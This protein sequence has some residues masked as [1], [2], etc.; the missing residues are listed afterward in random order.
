MRRLFSHTGRKRTARR[1]KPRLAF[2]PRRH[3]LTDLEW[4]VIFVATTEWIVDLRDNVELPCNLVNCAFSSNQ[5]GVPGFLSA[6]IRMDSDA[7]ACH[8]G[9]VTES[10]RFRQIDERQVPEIGRAHV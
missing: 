4:R 5:K 8:A 3:V 6:Q 7:T 1:T 10:I 2:E 9:S